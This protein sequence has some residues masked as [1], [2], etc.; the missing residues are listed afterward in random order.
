MTRVNKQLIL[1][2]GGEGGG[3]SLLGWRT[4]RG[5][6]RFQYTTD[7]TTL[8]CLLS[9]EDLR[10][11]PLTSCSKSVTGWPA[12]LRLLS[13]YPWQHLHPLSVHP[14]FAA[15]IFNEVVTAKAD[16]YS[17]RL[18]CDLCFPKS[19]LPRT[20]CF[21]HGKESGPW[22][23]KI[24]SL[25][26]V[27]KSRGFE[28]MTIDYRKEPS[29]ERRAKMLMSQSL[30][31]EGVNVLVGSSMGGYVSLLASEYLKPAGVFLMAPAIGLPGYERQITFSGGPRVTIVHGWD[32]KIVPPD[33]VIE[34][35]RKHRLVL[36]VVVDGHQLENSIGFLEHQFG[37]FLD[38]LENS[39]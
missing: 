14:E 5:E 36:H 16:E 1:A 38:S 35:A 25:A 7:E 10:G 3:I 29:P 19:S 2:V 8:K 23:K 30:P 28:V 20:V 22:G 21:S 26:A 6:W 31:T 39:G 32:D 18:W 27:A 12:A 4:S 37:L 11:M 15:R 33:N 24:S 9:D 17:Q 13:V 34:F